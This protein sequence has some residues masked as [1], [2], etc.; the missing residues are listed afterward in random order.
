MRCWQPLYTAVVSHRRDP[1][2]AQGDTLGVRALV[3]R[4]RG[5]RREHCS[6]RMIRDFGGFPHELYQ[7]RYPAPGDP[8][9]A[10]RVQKLLAPTPVRR[11]DRWGFD[12][13]TWSVL[14][15]VYPQAD[16]LVVQLSIDE[17]QPPSFH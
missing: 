5:G 4:R 1:A 14:F 2:E 7:L 15:H 13:G 3:H 16:I 8:G 17:R 10:A 9:L 6:P 12:H 11:D